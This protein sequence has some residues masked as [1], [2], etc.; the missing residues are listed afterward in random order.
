MA[1]SGSYPD[2]LHGQGFAILCSGCEQY[3]NIRFD[4]T[5]TATNS[6]YNSIANVS[7]NG[8]TNNKAREF[9]IGVKNVKSGKDLANAIFEGVSAVSSQIKGSYASQNTASNLLL[10]NNHNVRIKRDPDGKV[11]LTKTGTLEMQ[12]L[13][14]TITNPLTL[15]LLESKLES[16]PFSPLWIQHGTQSSQRIHVF[17]GDMQTKALGIDKAEVITREKATSAIGTIESAIETALNEATN[18]GAYLQRIETAFDNVVTMRENTQASESVI[19]DVDMAKE[20]TD[21]TKYNLLSRSSQAMLA[22]ANQNGSFV[23]GMFEW[24][25]NSSGETNS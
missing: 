17:V 10:D 8:Q 6:T 7:A 23:L 13:D 20:V 11:Y 19:R 16:K 15:P 3:I 24:T 4:A 21:Y 25:G 5:K 22:Q 18:M 12:F 9:T 14:G 2:S 1:V